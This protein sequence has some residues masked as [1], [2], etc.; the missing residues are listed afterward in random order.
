MKITLTMDCETVQKRGVYPA[1]PE[2]WE[3]SAVNI[4][5]FADI[6]ESYDHTATFYATPEAAENHVD[7]FR[8]LKKIGHKVGLHLHPQTYRDGIDSNLGDLSFME[9]YSLMVNAYY[10]FKAA[11]GFA[12][13][14]FRPGCFSH[15]EDTVRIVNDF[16]MQG[17]FARS[18]IRVSRVKYMRH[19][20]SAILALLCGGHLYNAACICK[21]AL[22]APPDLDFVIDGWEW[23][24]LKEIVDTGASLTLLTHNYVDYANGRNKKLL[25]KLLEYLKWTDS[26]T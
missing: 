18:A 22:T 24:T 25:V 6:V 1:G 13:I 2:S 17:D 26:K 21:H 3:E 11:L 19:C 20:L 4:W 16:E 14:H 9:Q 23:Y 15:N 7:Q 10:D 5:S 12:P 8:A